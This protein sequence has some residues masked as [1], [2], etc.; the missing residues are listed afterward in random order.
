MFHVRVYKSNACARQPQSIQ[1]IRVI[2]ITYIY[3]VILLS[4]QFYNN[5]VQA[6]SINKTDK[7]KKYNIMWWGTIKIFY[8]FHHIKST[9]KRFENPTPLVV[10]ELVE[11]ALFKA[12]C[13]NNS[14]IIITL[15]TPDAPITLVV[16][17]SQ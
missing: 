5:K 17:C 15:I 16:N 2:H 14:V 8:W 10:P 7:A 13:V 11:W 4:K 9:V 12:R 6:S 1:N 3:F